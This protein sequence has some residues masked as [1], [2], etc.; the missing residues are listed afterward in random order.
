MDR[1]PDS[2]SPRCPRTPRARFA[3]RWRG[4]DVRAAG[5]WRTVHARVPR[6]AAMRGEPE[7]RA[8]SVRL[9][10]PVILVVTL[11]ALDFGEGSSPGVTVTNASRAGA[12]F[13]GLQPQAAGEGRRTRRSWPSTGPRSRPTC[14]PPT[15]RCRARSPSPSSAARPIPTARRVGHVTLTCT[16]NPINAA[17]PRHRRLEPAGH[18]DDGLPGPGRHDRRRPHPNAI[19]LPTRHPRRRRYR[20]RRRADGGPDTDADP[21]TAALCDAPAM[22][23]AHGLGR[24]S[25]W[26][27][28]GSR[29]VRRQPQRRQG[30]LEGHRPVPAFPSTQIECGEGAD[31]TAKK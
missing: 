1:A 12:A 3:A 20:R 26:I 31:I 15:A 30:H 17:G 13:A 4:E 5:G 29:A 2:P 11:L 14:C 19:P 10:L 7:A 8:S 25:A 9:V 22:T 24:T 6:T 21:D 28:P 16:F 27:G 18:L 23:G